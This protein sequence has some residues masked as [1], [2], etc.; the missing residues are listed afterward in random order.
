MGALAENRL[1]EAW[2]Q[3]VRALQLSPDMTLLWVNLG[4][5]Y[6]MADQYAAAESSYLQALA[7]DPGDR[8]AMTNLV[9]LYGLQERLEERDFWAARVDH[10]RNANPYY[11]AWLG[12][13]AGEAGDWPAALDHFEQALALSPRESHLL[14]ITGLA[15]YRLQDY[16]A[17]TDY[18]S[19][20]IDA[21]S[22]V[23]DQENYRV[24]LEAVKREQLAGI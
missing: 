8:S 13:Q 7:L 4:A 9:V 22:L 14:Y 18:I 21:A 12:E 24:Q 16:R 17:A 19:R 10:Y 23:S 1:G 2:M 11:H 15:H 20:A 5:V 6:R 3:L